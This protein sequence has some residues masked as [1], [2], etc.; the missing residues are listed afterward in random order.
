MKHSPRRHV[1]A[2]LRLALGLG[3]K[4]MADAVGT[5]RATIQAVE[6]G[7]LKLSNLLAMKISK[8]TGADLGWL[9]DND[10][11]APAIAVSGNPYNRYHFE[12]FQAAKSAPLAE[13]QIETTPDYLLSYY[14]RLRGIFASAG[15]KGEQRWQL[16]FY[17]LDCVIDDLRKEFGTDHEFDQMR[18]G[19]S[20]NQSELYLVQHDLRAA[21][22][23]FEDHNAFVEEILTAEAGAETATPA[24]EKPKPANLRKRAVAATN[25]QLERDGHVDARGKL[26]S[27]LTKPR[28]RDRTGGE[29]SGG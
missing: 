29:K 5:S 11:D 10:L 26:I 12:S 7:H 4:E 19:A 6:L 13:S 1:L 27:K 25:A 2:I 9:L 18:S 22:K 24:V 14:T 23:R 20:V 15:A 21:L 16:A 17:K 8:T 3:Q 28:R